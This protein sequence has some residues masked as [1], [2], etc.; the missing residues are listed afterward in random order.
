MALTAIL[1]GVLSPGGS[2]ESARATRLATLARSAGYVVRQN[3]PVFAARDQTKHLSMVVDSGAE[4]HLVSTGHKHL[5]RWRRLDARHDR[6][7]ALRWHRLSRR[8]FSTARGEK[9]GY[10]NQKCPEGYGVLK[11][12][13]G[14]V[15]LE[16]SGGLDYLV[17]CDERRV[18]P[19]LLTQTPRR[20]NMSTTSVAGVRSNNRNHIESS[21]G[22]L[23]AHI[24]VCAP[25]RLLSSSG[26]CASAAPHGNL[27]PSHTPRGIGARAE[28]DVPH[29]TL[30]RR[31]SSS[32]HQP[33]RN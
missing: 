18:F 23:P 15:K 32:V 2:S 21:T 26:Q 3:F 12:P 16:R 20:I 27:K 9:D 30:E 25:I 7:P 1:R 14:N 22:T 31:A 24:A 19:A 4:V 13:Q 33:E 28:P 17:G 29:T 10:F 6:G 5:S 11:R 8:F